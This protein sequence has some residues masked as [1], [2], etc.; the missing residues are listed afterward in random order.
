V[1]IENVR[2]LVEQARK[3]IVGGTP[4]Q[5]TMLPVEPSEMFPADLLRG[6]LRQEKHKPDILILRRHATREA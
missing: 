3:E 1:P 2:L 4:P 5:P 6:M